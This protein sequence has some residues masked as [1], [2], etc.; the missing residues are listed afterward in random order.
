[1][2]LGI[3]NSVNAASFDCA[4][5]SSR[6]ENTV[7]ASPKLSQ[8]DSQL[9]EIYS[10]VLLQHTD[11]EAVKNAQR[12]WLSGTRNKCTDESC[13]IAAYM[14][15]IAA[16]ITSLPKET[17]NAIAD[18][19][20]EDQADTNFEQETLATQKADYE[21][22]ALTKRQEEDAATQPKKQIEEAASKAKREIEESAAQ[23]QAVKKK[24]DEAR[25]WTYVQGTTGL[26]FLIAIFFYAFIQR[27]RR[28]QGSQTEY[29]KS[30]YLNKS[31]NSILREPLR[32]SEADPANTKSKFTGIA[33]SHTSN[34]VAKISADSSSTSAEKIINSTQE[35][36]KIHPTND[37]VIH[38]LI[39]SFKEINL[40]LKIIFLCIILLALF[41]PGLLF[42]AIL[43]ILILLAIKKKISTL[44]AFSFS[45]LALITTVI[46][47]GVVN[48]NSD[49][50]YYK[51]ASEV[52]L[53][54]ILS[55]FKDIKF[56]DTPVKIAQNYTFEDKTQSHKINEEALEK[57]DGFPPLKCYHN[58]NN[59]S[60]ES[61][62]WKIKSSSMCFDNEKL[63]LVNFSLKNI[64]AFN[65]VRNKINQ[66]L[67]QEG[68]IDKFSDNGYRWSRTIN[69][70]KVDTRLDLLPSGIFY[71]EVLDHKHH[72]R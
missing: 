10:T 4:L 56:G 34:D 39:K 8:L 19:Q 11:M 55:S 1:M 28:Q 5:A 41:W 66:M 31:I 2:S 70:I 53:T 71:F 37:G 45:I 24:D 59:T 18:S 7:C 15:R 3:N 30:N 16:L 52:E 36:T 32:K 49:A 72:Q 42:F 57:S 38:Y 22:A 21:S 61:T 35:S 50:A 60:S 33:S 67:G 27:K 40:F 29:E 46:V 58:Y 12:D 63:M 25:F 64:E 44:K 47:D 43:A 23:V 6:I 62:P 26:A 13:F 17:Q 20:Q 65:E 69:G 14:Q 51:S 54:P 68:V 9:G 48:K